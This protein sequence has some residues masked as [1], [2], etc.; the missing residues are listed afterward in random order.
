MWPRPSQAT[1][2]RDVDD[3][4][5]ARLEHRG[6]AVLAPERDPL[7]VDCRAC[8]SQIALVG[9]TWTLP[10]SGSMTPALL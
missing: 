10:S 2:R 8:V 1:K 3:R 7:D 9:V 5:T 6:D 4:A